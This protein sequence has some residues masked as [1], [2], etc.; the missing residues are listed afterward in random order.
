M[1]MRA[2]TGPIRKFLIFSG[3]FNIIFA[4]PL[5]IP[6]FADNYLEVMTQL[7]HLLG[8]GN[9]GY[10]DAQNATHALLISTAGI[11]LVLIGSIII[12]ASFD[13]VRRKGLLILNAAGRTLFF[14]I[15]VQ[16]ML[17]NGL[18]P[19]FLVFGIIDALIS[20]TFVVIYRQLKTAEIRSSV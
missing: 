13:P 18:M 7:N 12:Y 11:D 4:F 10:A 5:I 19:L 20:V 6:G 3:L 15:I 17:Y 8:L 14:L 1:T 16:Q 9:Q 2:N